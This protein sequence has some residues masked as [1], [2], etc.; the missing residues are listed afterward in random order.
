MSSYRNLNVWKKAMDFA[1]RIYEL[2]N[3]FP[4]KEAFSLTNQIRRASISVPSNIAEGSGR[5]TNK[6]Y[7]QFITIARGSLC[8]L[9]THLEIAFRVGYIQ[10]ELF[11]KLLIETSEIG[12]MLNGMMRALK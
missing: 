6:D 9:E 1:V 3:S 11:Q 10:K 2:T 4:Q 12:K 8:E 7:C 5:K